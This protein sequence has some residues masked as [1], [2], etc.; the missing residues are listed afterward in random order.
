MKEVR[1]HLN[2]VHKL[3]TF[4]TKPLV[5]VSL[6]FLFAYAGYIFPSSKTD[7]V[8]D[9]HFRFDTTVC[10]KPERAHVVRNNLIDEFFNGASPYLNFPPKHL[11]NLLT[12]AK[13]NGWDSNNV[14][15]G[16]LMRKYRPKIIIEI[17]TFLGMSTIHMTELSKEL[18]LDSQI[19]CIDNFRAWPGLD[20]PMINGDVL[21]MY[22]FIQNLVH[23]NVTDSVVY[24]PYSATIALDKMCAMGIYGDMIEVDAAHDFHSAWSDI[25]R[26]YKV[27]ARNG[28]IFGH[29]YFNGED[30]FG[31]RRAVDLF[32]RVKGLRVG[33]DGKHWVIHPS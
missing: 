13:I 2:Y 28:V 7:V 20:M 12:P 9:D 4:L 32:A 1:N 16:N 3:Y 10:A 11:A 17:G 21:L 15:F 19:I 18:G 24:L 6:L 25:N 27:L 23:K 33:T 31:V 30:H 26:A 5:Y 8:K 22:Q 29:D 14:V